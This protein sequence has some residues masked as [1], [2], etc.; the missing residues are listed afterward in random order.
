M[1]SS[2]STLMDVNMNAAGG[3]SQ[4]KTGSG[5]FDEFGGVSSRAKDSAVLGVG[6]DGLYVAMDTNAAPVTAD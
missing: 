2:P 3:A 4:T 5:T 1:G 6:S